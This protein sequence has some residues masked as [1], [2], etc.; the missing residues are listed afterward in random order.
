[1]A[2]TDSALDR[3]LMDRARLLLEPPER[4]GSIWAPLCA[5]AFLAVSAL[6]FATSMIMSPALVSEHV[7]STRGVR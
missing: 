7:A 1:M 4:S 5:A 3:D 6:A 2:A